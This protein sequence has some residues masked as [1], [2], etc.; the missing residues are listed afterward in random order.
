MSDTV[1]DDLNFARMTPEMRETLRSLWPII[2]QNMTTILDGMYAHILPRPEQKS[3]SPT[4]DTVNEARERQ[5]LHWQHVFS[6]SCDPEYTASVRRI[7]VTHARIGLKP[8]AYMSAYLTALEEIHAI[9]IAAFCR[10]LHVSSFRT[11]LRQAIQAVDRAVLFDLQLVV[12]GNLT[13]TAHDYGRRLTELCNQ[14]AAGNEPAAAG[15]AEAARGVGHASGTLGPDATTEAANLMTGAAYSPAVMQAMASTAEEIT[16][17]FGEIIRQTQQAAANTDLAVSSAHHAGEILET[18]NATAIRIGDVINLI[19]S[20]AEQTNLLALNA[21]IEAAGA[22]DVSKDFAVV[23]GEVRALSVQAA[24]ATDDIRVQ[25][26]AVH[27]VVVQIAQAMTDIAASVDRIGDTAGLNSGPAEPRGEA[28][29]EISRSVAPAAAG[30]PD[31]T[32][33]VHQVRSR[34]LAQCGKRAGRGGVVAGSDPAR[35]AVGASG[36]SFHGQDPQCR[37][38]GGTGLS[39]GF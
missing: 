10:G 31:I 28:T 26:D 25:I 22:G 15:P 1:T 12:T 36:Q 17:S 27:D 14:F 24:R 35:K 16:A 11:K 5:Q 19:Q 9:V 8:S 18:L 34:G 20:M 13:E 38:A 21:S 7:A 32:T 6:G 4:E 29:Q 33:G 39:G 2:D 30:L 37:R 23:A 3:L